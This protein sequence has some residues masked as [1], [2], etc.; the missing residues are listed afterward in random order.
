MCVII[1]RKPGVQIPGD[2]IELACDINKDGYGIAFADRGRLEIIKS[3]KPNDPGEVMKHLQDL[4]AHRV[5]LHLRHATVGTV[6]PENQH[7]FIAYEGRRKKAIIG[8]MHNGTL[9]H[10][11][12]HFQDK[13][14]SDTLLFTREFVEPLFKRVS[15]SLGEKNII[16]DDFVKHLLAKEIGSVSKVVFFDAFGNALFVNKDA[17]KQFEGWWASNDYSFDKQHIRSSSR[18]TPSWV[19]PNLGPKHDDFNRDYLGD[20]A[21]WATAGDNLEN[22]PWMKEPTRPRSNIIHVAAWEQEFVKEKGGDLSSK[23][24]VPLLPPPCNNNTSRNPVRERYEAQK[25]GNLCKTAHASNLKGSI[26]LMSSDCKS[27]ITRSEKITRDPFIKQAGLASLD[28]VGAFSEDD[29]VE[30]ATSWPQATAHLIID[31]LH[32]RVG[33]RNSVKKYGDEAA[34]LRSEAGDKDARLERQAEYV[35]RVL[36]RYKAMTGHSYTEDVADGR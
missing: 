20:A 18:K 3:T 25:L 5:F 12:P 6:T 9:H 19:N 14:R 17:G 8:M 11:S 13:T 7:P 16:L 21:D 27:V 22:L 24:S 31:L 36:R 29:L 32:E 33:Y 35:Q 30:C 28:M 1:D 10:Y 23:S 2:M 15:K 26:Y 4:V 34:K